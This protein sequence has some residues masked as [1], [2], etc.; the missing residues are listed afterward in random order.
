MKLLRVTEW[1]VKKEGFFCG[2]DYYDIT[3]GVV[4]AV[5]EVFGKPDHVFIDSSWAIDLSKRV[6]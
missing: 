4:K 3:P 6:I 2:H 1:A 5:D